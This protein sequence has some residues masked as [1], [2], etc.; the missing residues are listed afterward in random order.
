MV[1]RYSIICS[2]R[3]VHSACSQFLS[4]LV[5][6]SMTKVTIKG[7]PRP[8][9]FLFIT[10]SREDSGATS[11][12]ALIA[13]EVTSRYATW[14]GG[15][16]RGHHGM[17]WRTHG[18]SYLQRMLLYYNL[19]FLHSFTKYCNPFL[20]AFTKYYN[21]FLHAFTKF[22]KYV[23]GKV[24]V[25]T[26][27]D[28]PIYWRRVPGSGVIFKSFFPNASSTP[29]QLSRVVDVWSLEGRTESKILG[30]SKN[31]AGFGSQHTQN[32]WTVKI[33]VISDVLPV[34]FHKREILDF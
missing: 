27:I 6:N 20:H 12:R 5:S 8:L 7:L 17:P 31:N 18:A 1:W 19:Y 26:L 15:G 28:H 14:G 23:I 33:N 32:K 4:K 25:A 2:C 34:K 9:S 29:F 3:C 10:E 22:M 30:W 11:G 21:L 13:A 16:E 24:L